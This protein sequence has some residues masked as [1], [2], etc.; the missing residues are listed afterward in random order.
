MG[1]RRSDP[2]VR[3]ARSVAAVAACLVLANCA[4]SGKF[5]SRVDPKYGVSS[6]PRVVAFGEPVPKGGGTYRVGKPYTVGGRIYV[7]EEDPSYREE[8]MASWYGDDFH[9]RQTANGEVF[10]MTS[11]TAAHPTLPM[12]CYARVTNLGNGKSLIV[13]VNDRGPY[14]GNRLI[15]VSNRAAELLE[16]KGNGVA[17]VR[18]E[19]VARA[20]L[21]GSDDRQLVA[22]LRTGEPAPSPS[23]VRVASAHSFVPEIPSSARSIRGEVPMPEGRPYDLGNTSADMASISAT[24]EMSASGRRRAGS[25]VIENPRAVSYENDDRYAPEAGPVSAYAPIDPRGPSEILAGRG[26]Y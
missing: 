8:G 3:A 24:S 12:P 1:I 19:Y 2:V 10:D 7:P 23:L 22:T 21:E 16:F 14:H 26:L 18:V 5:A 15:D 25:R 6:S 9:G 4:S 11:L 17:R 13:R 20:P